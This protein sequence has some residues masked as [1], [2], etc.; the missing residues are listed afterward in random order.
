M[1]AGYLLVRT[2]NLLR[3]RIRASEL[4]FMGVALV[5]GS[6]AGIGALAMSSAAH[7]LQRLL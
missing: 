4:W 7:N 6:V 5:T 2:A 3:R 1:S